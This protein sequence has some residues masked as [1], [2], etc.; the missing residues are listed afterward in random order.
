MSEKL[1]FNEAI[2]LAEAIRKRLPL[3]DYMREKGCD[4]HN[5][6]AGRLRMSCPFHNENTPSFIVY[7]DTQTF[8]CFGCHVSGDVIKFAR[9]HN[10]WKWFYTI[11]MLADRFGLKH[12]VTDSEIAERIFEDYMRSIS[13][14]RVYKTDANSLNYDISLA[15]KKL[16]RKYGHMYQVRK[17][18][19]QMFR[20]ADKIFISEE[21]SDINKMKMTLIP[22]MQK[23]GEMVSAKGEK[24]EELAWR[25]KLC[26]SCFLGRTCSKIVSGTGNFFSEIMIVSGSPSDSD[27]QNDTAFHDSPVRAKINELGFSDNDVWFDYVSNCKHPVNY[28]YEEADVCK[29]LWLSKRID[30][31]KPKVIFALDE[32]SALSLLGKKQVY[33]PGAKVLT[34]LFGLDI[35]VWLA[36]PIESSDFTNQLN[37]LLSAYISK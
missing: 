2:R 32:Q 24:I 6:G 27:M 20:V 7:L 13:S 11:R 19:D 29:N 21:E 17:M 28:I 14:K 30:I 8:H 4:L 3:E 25:N 26:R 36:Y 16:F 34:K 12:T 10:N 15:G 23:Y 1:Y 9:L 5:A 18:I 22:Q 31:I 37:E 33:A 35:E